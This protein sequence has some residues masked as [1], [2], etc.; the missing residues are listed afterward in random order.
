MGLY[1]FL[2]CG[3]F[4]IWGGQ[5]ANFSIFSRG[6]E[7]SEDRCVVIFLH[8]AEFEPATC[9]IQCI[10][11]AH[12]NKTALC[13]YIDN[14]LCFLCLSVATVSSLAS[15]P[16]WARLGKVTRLARVCEPPRACLHAFPSL[17]RVRARFLIFSVKLFSWAR[18]QDIAA[19]TCL[20]HDAAAA[21][22]AAKIEHVQTLLLK[23][24]RD[25][26]CCM[27]L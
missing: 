21:A 4:G 2:S 1:G 10:Q 12:F 8:P 17:C 24:Q 20:P 22:A 5:I 26:S 27:L 11:I 13:L 25:C 9:G 18:A 19:T 23:Q 15:R 16:C 6:I 3:C 7:G 14:F